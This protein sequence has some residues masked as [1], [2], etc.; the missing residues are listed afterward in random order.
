MTPTRLRSTRCCA[1]TME[2]WFP[3]MAKPI[4][5]GVGITFFDGFAGPGEYTNS[6]VSSRRAIALEQAL[7]SDVAGRG[8]PIRLVFIEQDMRQSR[9]APARAPLGRPSS[10]QPSQAAPT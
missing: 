3:I 6:Q 10:P 4:P 8:T 9:S 5:R 1:A 2:A 7:R